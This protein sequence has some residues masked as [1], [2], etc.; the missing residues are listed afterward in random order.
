QI[1]NEFGG[2]LPTPAAI[3]NYLR[4]VKSNWATPPQYCLLF[5]DCDYDYRNIATAS[6]NWIPPWETFESFVPIST[7]ESEDEFVTFT[8]YN[9]GGN[10]VPGRVE[11]RLGRLAARSS[12]EANTMVDKI[13]E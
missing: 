1:Y 12:A 8:T 11:M 9:D 13:I 5:G 2:G 4:Y 7:F 3:R 6:T 10:I